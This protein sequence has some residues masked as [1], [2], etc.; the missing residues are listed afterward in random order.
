MITLIGDEIMLVLDTPESGPCSLAEAINKSL[1][2]E[3]TRTYQPLPNKTMLDMIYRIARED[4]IKLSNQQ[5]GLDLKGMRMFGTADIEAHDFFDGQIG[6]QI[7]WCNSY[8]G[9]MSARFCIGGK[10]FVCSNRCF[11]SYTDGT[12]ITGYIV[13]PHKNLGDQGI[14][15]GL[16]DNIRAAF[17]QIDDFKRSQEEF[18]GRM[19][20]RRI[21]TD[22]AYGTI[23]R[24]A[25]AG[26]INKTKVLTL[27][28][29]WNRQ[30]V[31]PIDTPDYEWHPE[32]QGRNAYSLFNAFTQVE[33]TRLAR[34]PVAS[35]ISTM[36]LT[37][38][39]YKEF[40]LN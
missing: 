13:R 19:S 22:T 32:F 39:F 8:N 9:T 31:E 7:G 6:L 1:I 21:T 36:D 16:I 37:S 18:Y 17:Q 23:V 40:N 12:G 29:E 26:V 27:A 24:A 3:A 28:D 20:D 34:N 2:P 25:Q 15:D 11:Y 4:G 10:V 5:L 30:A 35:N 38:F 33:K 14:R